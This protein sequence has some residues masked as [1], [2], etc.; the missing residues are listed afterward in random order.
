M[1]PQPT[2][3]LCTYC[4][5]HLKPDEK[6]LCPNVKTTSV[7]CFNTEIITCLFSNQT[8]K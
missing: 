5:A 7:Y 2:K 1:N 8:K 4:K 6:H 3:I